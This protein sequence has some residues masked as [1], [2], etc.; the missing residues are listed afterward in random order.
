MAS[1]H[2]LASLL[3]FLAQASVAAM[4]KMVPISS[5]SIFFWLSFMEDSACL[6]LF[7]LLPIAGS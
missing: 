2:L 5:L 7:I 3:I 1:V 6:H 4:V